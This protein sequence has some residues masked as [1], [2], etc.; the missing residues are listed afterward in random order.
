MKSRKFKIFSICQ[1]NGT[2][3]IEIMKQ[4][5]VLHRFFIINCTLHGNR[6][7]F[8]REFKRVLWS[9]GGIWV[10][11]FYSFFNARRN[12]THFWETVPSSETWFIIQEQFV[13]SVSPFNRRK[14]LELS[15]FRMN[16]NS[17][18]LGIKC[19]NSQFT[20]IYLCSMTDIWMFRL[21]ICVIVMVI[22][23]MIKQLNNW[24]LNN[25]N[26]VIITIEIYS[27]IKLN[28][29]SVSVNANAIVYP[30][31]YTVHCAL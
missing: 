11:F 4:R 18:C 10:K 7:T 9:Y 3:L 28:F 1:L 30:E 8:M 15:E 26:C 5:I 23:R 31:M 22:F 20:Y 19:F 25:L 17:I 6:K 2:T 13:L 27:S 21:F 12:T 16:I 24:T 14:L 29:S